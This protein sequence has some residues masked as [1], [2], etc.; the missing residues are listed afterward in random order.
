MSMLI[1]SGALLQC[2][3]GAAPALLNVLPLKRVVSG[4]PVANVLDHLP[5]LNI[6][7]FGTCSCIANPLV[8]A[9][10]AAALGALTPAPCLPATNAPW[11][12]GSP[13]VLAGAMPAL[14]GA[15]ALPC[16]WGGA[17]RIVAPAQF[18]TQVA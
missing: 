14:R 9:A 8:A 12:S 2:T 17:I 5:L 1:T 10:T 16:N 3:F 18:A 13:T 7:S 11:M 4:A 15:S 6:P